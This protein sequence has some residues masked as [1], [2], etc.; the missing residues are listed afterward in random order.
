MRVIRSV[1]TVCVGVALLLG[2]LAVG[3]D[4]WNGFLPNPTNSRIAAVAL[5]IVGAGYSIAQFGGT[6]RMATRLRAISLGTAFVLWGA[7][8][9]LPAGRVGRVI[10]CVLVV[11]F[12]VDLS[13]SIMKRLQNGSETDV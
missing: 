12:V 6:M 11:V 1:C 3:W 8:P 5:M 13:L 4:V 7:S 9:F 2:A 10:D